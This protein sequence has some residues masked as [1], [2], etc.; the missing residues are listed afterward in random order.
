MM[1]AKGMMTG[2]LGT[3]LAAA[4]LTQKGLVV[5]ITSRNAR[6]ADLLVTDQAYKRTWSIQVKTNRKAASFWLLSK[7]YRDITSATH[8]YVFINLRGNERPDYYVVPS[9]VV[10]KLGQTTTEGRSIFYSFWRKDAKRYHERWSI[11]G[12]PLQSS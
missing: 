5:S 12:R 10:A 7:D 6:G 8:I 11:F 9:G 2:M 3:Y 1:A 4:E